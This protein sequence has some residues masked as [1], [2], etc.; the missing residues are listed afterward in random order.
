M[1]MLTRIAHAGFMFLILQSAFAIS[2]ELYSKSEFWLSDGYGLLV[3]LNGDEL[4]AYELTSISCIPGWHAKKVPQPEGAQGTVYSGREQYRLTDGPGKTK[5]LRMD[6]TVSDII[7]HRTNSLPQRCLQPPSDSQQSNYAIFWQTFAEQY[8]FFDLHKIDWRSV[9]RKFRPQVTANVTPEE[10]FEIFRQMIEPLQDTHTVLFGRNIKKVFEG[11]RTDPNQLD[12]ETWDKAAKVIDNYYIRGGLRSFCNGRLQFGMLDNSIGYLR[13]TAFYGYSDAD[14]YEK[15]LYAL[16]TA[17]D[18][19]FNDAN[20]MRGLVID[21]RLNHGGDDPLGIEIASRLTNIR[22]LAY[23]KVARN[24]LKGP[25]HYTTPQG[26]WVEPSTRPGFH[27]PVVLLTGPDTISA[28]ETF[29]MALMGHTPHI[30]RIGLNTQGVF[31]DVLKRT[32]PNGWIFHLPNE[33]YLTV[34]GK[35]F[36]AIGIPPDLKIKFFSESDLRSGKD[37]ALEAALQ[38]LDGY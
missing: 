2:Q 27:G 9:D 13:I 5:R 37:A 12:D 24:N 26:S 28:G 38:K 16:Q 36:D 35:A 31:S 1:H 32:L 14:N 20:K 19:I 17:L 7:L 11:S 15:E 29:T 23:N 33:V 18:E 21:V 34:D 25:L 8:G 4:H 6:G 30:Q 3:T 10:L 22:Y